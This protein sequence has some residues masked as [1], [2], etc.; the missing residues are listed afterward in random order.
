MLQGN[1][2]FSSD[3]DSDNVFLRDKAE[4]AAV[5]GIQNIVT[6]HKIIVLTKGIGV[7][8]TSF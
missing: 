2:F 5:V 1:E 4:V 8:R 3:H 7:D 6:R